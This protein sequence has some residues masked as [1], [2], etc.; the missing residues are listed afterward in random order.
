MA[1]FD[2]LLNIIAPKKKL[3]AGGSAITATYSPTQA[4]QVLTAPSFA[5]FREDIFTT[6]Q[7]SDSRTLMKALFR[8]DPDVSSTVNGYLTLADTEIVMWAEDAEGAI[9]PVASLELQ[10]IL[11]RLTRQVDYTLGFQLKQSIYQTC[12]DMRYMLLL[13]GGVGLEL[14]FDKTQNPDSIRQIDLAS[15]VW[16]EKNAGEYKPGQ[17]VAGKSDPQMLDTPAFFVSFY[18]RDPT[19]IYADSPFVSAINTI[20]ARQQVI[21]DLY[22]IMQQ[23]GF[24]RMDIKILEEVVL[25]NAPVNVR[26]DADKL[27]TYV[28]DSIAALAGQFA[29]LR[30]DQSIVHTD[31]V[32]FS[33]LNDKNPGVGIDVTNVIETLNAQNQ[34]ALKTMATILGRGSAG[35]NTGSVEARLA[36]MFAD[37]LN[38]PLAEILEKMLSFCLHQRGYQG[39]ANVKFRPAELRPDTELEPQRVMKANRLRQD[40]SDGIITDEEYTLEMYGR[41]PSPGATPLSGTGFVNPVPLAEPGVDGK[42]P[43]PSDVPAKKGPLNKAIS[44]A[45]SGQAKA[46]TPKSSPPRPN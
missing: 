32:E 23:T 25:N 18:R 21:N 3:P 27:K 37:E 4:Q 44:P 39:F 9:D 26:Q 35:V 42:P 12:A 46:N 20:A 38:E 40:L 1:L 5:S 8:Q 24:P 14:I 41:L 16:F 19:V 28:A 45:K 33:I 2:G 29:N 31:A 36:A 11:K 34:A 43:Q 30:S 17:T 7:A 22:R 15:I 13:R 6:R 10:A